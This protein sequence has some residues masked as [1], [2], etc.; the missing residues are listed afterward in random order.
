MKLRIF[1]AALLIAV[2]IAAASPGS[3]VAA[4]PPDECVPSGN[5]IVD[6]DTGDEYVYGL[7]TEVGYDT[8]GNPIPNICV[9]WP[10]GSYS[11]LWT[12]TPC[13]PVSEIESAPEAQPTL[14]DTGTATWYVAALASLLLVG[15]SGL[16]LLAR[17][18]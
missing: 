14:P 6:V 12:A 7:P 5:V 18:L 3:A 1:G 2:A 15:G 8:C 9:Q 17:R 4:P 13:T 10:G 16:R 11:R